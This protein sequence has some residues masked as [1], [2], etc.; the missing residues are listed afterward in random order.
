MLTQFYINILGSAPTPM[1]T[2]VDISQ[3]VNTGAVMKGAT[4]TGL[5]GKGDAV[6]VDAKGL[7]FVSLGCPPTSTVG[8]SRSTSQVGIFLIGYT[9]FFAGNAAKVG[10]IVY[11]GLIEGVGLA[12]GSLTETIMVAQF[13]GYGVSTGLSVH[14][15][16]L[17]QS[18]ILSAIENPN[19]IGSWLWTIGGCHLVVF[20]INGNLEVYTLH[21]RNTVGVGSFKAIGGAGGSKSYNH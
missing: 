4:S 2:F 11:L 6:V 5:I 3:T 13:Q 15:S 16:Y 9:P 17:V 19:R 10:T 20:L 12:E 7:L 1:G 14:I 21:G 8:A 18:R